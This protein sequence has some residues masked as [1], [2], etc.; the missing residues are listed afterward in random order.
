MH[1]HRNK[2]HPAAL[3]RSG[4]TVPCT[5]R[6]PRL[7]SRRPVVK[8]DELIRV[9]EPELPVSHCVH[10]DRRVLL[11]FLVPQKLARHDGNVPRRRQMLSR[12][13]TIVQSRAVDKV[14]IHHSEL[15]RPFVHHLHKRRLAS[16]HMLC[17]RAR[18]VVGRRYHHGLQH[19]LKRQLLVLLQIDLAPALSCRGRGGRDHIIPADPPIL[20][21]FH[22]QKQ[23][24]HLRHARR[25]EPFVG[26]ILIENLSRRP[27]HQNARRRGQLQIRRPCHPGK[28]PRNHRY[29]RQK[30]SPSLHKK[31][32]LRFSLVQAY[33]TKGNFTTL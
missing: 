3:S 5:R 18:A 20:Q 28:Y 13:S 25:P 23:R 7:E 8:P 31:S 11:D 33:E 15:L 21:R 14:R 22:H 32:P 9:A 29:Q 12:I 27:L 6:V 30:R 1:H 16:R 17:Q 26:V 19:L 24:H 10:P 4:Q 2:L